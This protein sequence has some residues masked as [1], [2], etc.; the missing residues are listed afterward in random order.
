MAST[1]IWSPEAADDLEQI[2]AFIARD[3]PR[4]AGQVASAVFDVVGRLSLLP[5]SGGI[6]SEFDDTNIRGIT[7]YSYRL[8]YRVSADSIHIAA[9]IHGARDLRAALTDRH[10]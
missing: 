7:I 1:I 8:I 10:V 2:V 3:S 6:V 5:R 4:Y 9:I